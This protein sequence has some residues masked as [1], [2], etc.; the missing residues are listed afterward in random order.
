MTNKTNNNKSKQLPQGIT[1]IPIY[2]EGHCLALEFTNGVNRAVFT[3]EAIKNWTIQRPS[4]EEGMG[5]N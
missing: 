1:V 3:L 4:L 2:R 5:E